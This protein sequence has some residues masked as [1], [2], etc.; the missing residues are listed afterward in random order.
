MITNNQLQLFQ[1][2]QSVFR[3]QSEDAVRNTSL[4]SN[5][6]DYTHWVKPLFDATR[7]HLASSWRQGMFGG[8]KKLID[9]TKGKLVL[10][11][12]HGQRVHIG[13][14]LHYQVGRGNHVGR[15]DQVANSKGFPGVVRPA[16]FGQHLGRIAV[17]KSVRM[18]FSVHNPKVADAV[19]ELVL[20]F[21]RETNKAV[22]GSVKETRKKI[23][24]L[25]AKGLAKGTATLVL[26]Q[27][28]RK[29]FTD[30]KRSWRI[31]VTEIPRASAAGEIMSW[32]ESGAV[33]KK[34]WL[35]HPDACDRCLALEDL[36][37]IP[38]DKPFWVDP[39]GGPYGVVM[40]N[41]LHPHDQCS[42]VPVL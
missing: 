6:D 7:P 12:G 35:A 36:G 2:L 34:R 27:Q 28:I 16:P 39:E 30:P 24:E 32:K 37:D 1:A 8:M 41:P 31:T 42:I 10:A 5:E 14:G 40:H 11:V 4:E 26:H 33:T 9:L 13:H 19:D 20:K 25:I 3:R 18:D 15:T 17:Q 22:V 38:L 23:K 21:C 29:L